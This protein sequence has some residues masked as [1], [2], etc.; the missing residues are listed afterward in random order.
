MSIIIAIII[1]WFPILIIFL[2]IKSSSW[3][4]RLDCVRMLVNKMGGFG[5]LSLYPPLLTISRRVLTSRF[6]TSCSAKTPSRALTLSRWEA[7]E[8]IGYLEVEIEDR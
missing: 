2:R 6:I 3:L 7:R 5:A 4:F 1:T 8:R